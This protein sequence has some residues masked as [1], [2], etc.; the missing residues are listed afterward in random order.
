MGCAKSQGEPDEKERA[1]NLV[2]E[3]SSL[4]QK[5]FLSSTNKFF[6]YLQKNTNF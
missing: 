5:F 3:K 4:L 1:L 2:V 6:E